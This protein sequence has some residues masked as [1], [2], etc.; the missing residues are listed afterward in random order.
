MKCPTICPLCNAKLQYVYGGMVSD[1]LAYCVKDNHKNLEFTAES[2]SKERTQ[3][4]QLHEMDSK[5]TLRWTIEKYGDIPPDT[6][7]IGT[8]F[9][10]YKNERI[11]WSY[12]SPLMEKFKE[13]IKKLEIQETFS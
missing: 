6:L 11:D 10:P 13:I 8:D 3:F 12:E 5:I 2:G 7:T 1:D 4:I 9:S